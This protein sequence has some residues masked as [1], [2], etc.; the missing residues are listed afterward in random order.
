MKKKIF[1]DYSKIIDETQ[2]RID[3]ISLTIK[4]LQMNGHCE[5]KKLHK[6]KKENMEKEKLLKKN[7][8]SQNEKLIKKTKLEQEID[9]KLR[10][11]EKRLNYKRNKKFEIE[12]NT[13]SK[14]EQNN[15]FVFEEEK[16]K[17]NIVVLINSIYAN[18][19]IKKKANVEFDSEILVSQKPKLLKRKKKKKK[20]INPGSAGF[21]KCI[22]F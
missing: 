15:K 12:E 6:K 9:E 17:K 1:N 20:N 11:F 8:D 10:E 2:E 19:N 7:L 5:T 13:I 21:C 4:N 22:I 3:D 16:L 14:T 18:K